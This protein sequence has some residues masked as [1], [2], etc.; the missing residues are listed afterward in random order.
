MQADRAASDW[1]PTFTNFLPPPT[2]MSIKSMV[3]RLAH[4]SALE[5][6]GY[7]QAER[8]RIILARDELIDQYREEPDQAGAVSAV[9]VI[10]TPSI[11]VHTITATLFDQ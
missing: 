2:A 8:C 11:H 1:I 5:W 4:V 3:D 9:K 6:G 10:S 7:P